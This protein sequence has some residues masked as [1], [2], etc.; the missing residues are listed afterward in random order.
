M[1]TVRTELSKLSNEW[2]ADAN[3]IACSFPGYTAKQGAGRVMRANDKLHQRT[4]T[5]YGWRPDKVQ[6]GYGG[7]KPFL[8]PWISLETTYGL[9]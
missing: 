1:L 2:F 8:E 5:P 7:F 6:S 9:P 3:A 4:K